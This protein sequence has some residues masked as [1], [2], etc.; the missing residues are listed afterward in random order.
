MVAD[1]ESVCETCLDA[2]TDAVMS[3]GLAPEDH[4]YM[5]KLARASGG[6]IFDHWCE[7][8]DDEDVVCNCGCRRN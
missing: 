7:A 6:D 4:E 3:L 2:V 1:K 5:L 8:D